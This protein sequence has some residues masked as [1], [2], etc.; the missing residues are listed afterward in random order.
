MDPNSWNFW[1]GALKFGAA[2]ILVTALMAVVWGAIL[3]GRVYHSADEE[4]GFLSPGKWV[5][6]TPEV[7]DD[8]GKEDD[9]D[10]GEPDVIKRGW[11]ASA[12]W[13]VWSLMFAL[14]VTISFFAA[15]LPWLHSSSS[16]PTC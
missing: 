3:P 12:L 7:V 5:E 10:F 6:G 4:F 16:P 1:K 9:R 2:L 11:T 13:V 15:R 14:S 8:V